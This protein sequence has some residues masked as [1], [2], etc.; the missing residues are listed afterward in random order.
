MEEGG[1]EEMTSHMYIAQIQLTLCV[2]KHL[3]IP[4]NKGRALFRVFGLIV[5]RAYTKVML[6]DK[7][8]IRLELISIVMSRVFM[9]AV[10]LIAK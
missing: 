4:S 2:L 8:S 5:N 10:R 3:H 7:V 6:R 9:F 1:G